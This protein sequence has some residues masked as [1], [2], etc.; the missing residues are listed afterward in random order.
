[1]GLSRGGRAN[2][3]IQGMGEVS[4]LLYGAWRGVGGMIKSWGLKGGKKGTPRDR[5]FY[6]GQER[7]LL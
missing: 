5:Q 6:R 7:W 3:A 2:V 1:M 4:S